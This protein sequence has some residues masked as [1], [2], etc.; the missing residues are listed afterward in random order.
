VGRAGA[1]ADTTIRLGLVTSVGALTPSIRRGAEFGHSEADLFAKL[2]GKR[3][4][5]LVRSAATEDGCLAAGLELF[6][7]ERVMAVIGGTTDAAAE[8]LAKAAQQASG[9]FLNVGA[10]ASRLRGP[11]FDRRTFHV[12]P[13][14]ATLVNAAGLRLIEQ[15]RR[16][17]WGV[18]VAESPFGS[19][20]EAA[21][22]TLTAG[23]SAPV[24]VQERLAASFG[25]WAALFGR[26][27]DAN[28][29]ALLAGLPPEDMRA[30]LAG[31]RVAGLSC[32]LA[33]VPSDPHFALEA[34]AASLEGIWPLAWHESLERY[35]ARELNGR[36]RRGFQRPL[37]PA[38]WAAWAAVKL[39][40][41]AAVRGNS[42]EVEPLRDFLE[43]RLAFDGHKGTAL[44]FRSSDR[45]LG[46]PLYIVRARPGTAA[47]L[48][49]VAELS[50]D[51][52]DAV[53]PSARERE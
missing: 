10:I 17:R 51:R 15:G 39:V 16:T 4:E 20:V 12:H 52:L 9:L 27:R 19:E 13:G 25:D 33:G 21:A 11:L 43:S 18:I 46:Q 38:A 35:S 37:D 50:Q 40:V 42:V 14:V 5:L 30:F 49:V 8:A 47:G 24:V 53:A 44:S 7:G 28:V 36:Y 34:D 41:E 45:E 29:D 2:F 31:Y 22:S 1:A 26:L 3:V 6:R 48:E 32:E 23:I